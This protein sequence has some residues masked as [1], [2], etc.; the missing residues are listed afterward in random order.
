MDLPK[1]LLQDASLLLSFLFCPPILASSNL[2][3]TVEPNNPL[4]K[5]LPT[6]QQSTLERLESTSLTGI[7][8]DRVG[9]T[10]ADLRSSSGGG[11]DSNG[12]D[13]TRVHGPGARTS[14]QYFLPLAAS[15]SCCMCSWPSLTAQTALLSIFNPPPKPKSRLTLMG[16]RPRRTQYMEY[17]A[18][19]CA[20]DT[21]LKPSPDA[22][23]LVIMPVHFC[24]IRHIVTSFL[25]P[26]TSFSTLQIGIAST[27]VLYFGRKTKEM[28]VGTYS[29]GDKFIVV[30]D[31]VLERKVY[32]AAPR[33]D[34]AITRFLLGN[35]P[36]FS[37]KHGVGG[38]RS[39]LR[40]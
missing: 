18:T 4:R 6:D 30:G 14:V 7:E 37:V 12:V 20:G 13:A 24:D 31:R 22:L 32:F 26:P 2:C 10:F 40:A 8:S 3:L 9:S 38:H 39:V 36:V 27:I 1:L 15:S 19:R 17:S 28:D 35:L 33:R 21:A 5:Y 16:L 29:G 34:N 25:I 23:N 11:L